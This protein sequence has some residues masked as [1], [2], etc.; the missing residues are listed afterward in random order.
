MNVH[1]FWRQAQLGGNLLY[2]HPLRQLFRHF[3]FAFGQRVP[4]SGRQLHG[5]IRR[6]IAAAGRHGADGSD[7]LIRAA[8]LGEKTARAG[9]QRLLHQRR[10]VV[11]RQHYDR[12]SFR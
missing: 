9:V 7:Q 11:H 6:Q 4:S 2:R 10:T 8:A 5:D 1:G 3:A 12:H